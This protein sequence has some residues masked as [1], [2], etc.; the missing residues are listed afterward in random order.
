MDA[1][2]LE[3][4][5]FIA[6]LWPEI[7]A[8]LHLPI[9]T[10][11]AKETAWCSSVN[12]AV[13]ASVSIASSQ[14]V[15]LSV[16]LQDR[17]AA[18]ALNGP[19]TRGL[20]QT[21]AAITGLWIDIDVL[22][23]GHSA[24]NLPA[25]YDE[26]FELLAQMRLEPSVVVRSGGGLQAW[27]LFVEPWVFSDAADRNRAAVLAASWVMTAQ[28]HAAARQWKV[29]STKDLA[30]VLRVAGTVN[31]KND[32]VLVTAE[33]F[34]HRYQPSDF[35][36]FIYAE[37]SGRVVAEAPGV[38]APEEDLQVA[39]C[40]VDCLSASR[41][42][43]RDEWIAI[44][45]ALKSLGHEPQGFAMFERFSR[46]SDK[47]DSV[48]CRETWNTFKPNGSITLASLVFRARKDAGAVRGIDDAPRATAWQIQPPEGVAVVV[49]AP[50]VKTL[51]GTTNIGLPAGPR[52]RIANVID[53]RINVRD[54][55]EEKEVAVVNHL[56]LTHVAESLANA[57]GNW[58]RRA[59]GVLFV[60]SESAAQSTIATAENVSWLVN[61]D[62]LFAWMQRVADLRWT[63]KAATHPITGQ[64]MTPAAKKE[65][66]EY[67]I[68]YAQP[69]YKGLEVLPHEPALEHLFYVPC[70]LPIVGEECAALMELVDQFNPE[71]EHDRL[72]LLAALM[73]PGWGGP[74][75][76]RPVFLFTSE[77]GRGVGKSVTASVFADI[78]G[79]AIGIGIDEDWDQVRKR[80]LSDDALA[81]RCVMVD[82]VKHRMTGGDIEGMITAQVIDGWKPYHGQ[83]S[84]PNLLTWYITAN[85]PSLS[86][87][88]ADRSVVIKLGKQRPG[89][90]FLGWVRQHVESHRNEILA[91]LLSVLKRPVAGVIQKQHG[92]RWSAWQAGVLSKFGCADELAKL[93]L[94]RR[95]GVDSDLDDSEEVASIISEMLIEHFPDLSHRRIFFTR[96]QLHARCQ[97]KGFVDKSISS[98]AFVTIVRNM[99]NVGPLSAIKEHKTASDRGWVWIG[100]QADASTKLSE[101]PETWTDSYGKTA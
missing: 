70:N 15:Y 95:Q 76:A 54:G 4:E 37:L 81:K 29:D 21:A 33:Y 26:A 48:I 45:M 9:F 84:R 63:T 24:K 41:S 73:T 27:W 60:V 91:G 67:L 80:L 40:A 89:K 94:D 43:D 97:S 1:S 50:V 18:I 30:R 39:N 28:E 10:I 6:T 87:D 46:R 8:G 79:G 22:G 55:D 71:T 13:S 2:T 42:D 56:P 90:D 93:I 65:F 77:H 35:D 31:L 86:R 53:K 47:Y 96:K 23:P 64:P 100:E 83:A 32:P 5:K 17:V 58:P 99:G 74:P 25:T 57:T 36:E 85:T 68:H 75:G 7:P 14:N 72:L 61:T 16:S 52:Q 92:D 82:N 20:A 49:A 19:G 34:E 44:G 98:R 51:I 78:W 66:F 11:P 101:L 69:T 59:G 62:K 88:L 3:V 38:A 12:V